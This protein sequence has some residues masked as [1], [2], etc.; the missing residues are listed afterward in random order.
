[1]SYAASDIGNIMHDFDQPYTVTFWILLVWKSSPYFCD[2]MCNM[3][4]I[5]MCPVLSNRLVVISFLEFSMAN[6]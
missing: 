2:H 4:N 3:Y 6:I 5:A 1:M